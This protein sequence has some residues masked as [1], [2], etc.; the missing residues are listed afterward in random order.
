MRDC[1]LFPLQPGANVK[2][3]SPSRASL[4]CDVRSRLVLASESASAFDNGSPS[5]QRALAT[6]VAE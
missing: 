1:L 5:L 6:L 2:L 3:C 4:F